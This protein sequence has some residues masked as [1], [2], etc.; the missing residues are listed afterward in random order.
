MKGM[1]RSAIVLQGVV[2]RTGEHIAIARRS[3]ARLATL[4]DHGSARADLA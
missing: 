3:R 4:G 1:D 2:R